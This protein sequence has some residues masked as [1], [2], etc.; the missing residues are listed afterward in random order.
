MRSPRAVW[1]E[2]Q[3]R[4]LPSGSR[5]LDVGFVGAHG[6]P[7]LHLGLRSIRPDLRWLGLDVNVD[8]L[9]EHA[10]ASV[11]AA[12]GARLPF[13]DDSIDVLLFLEVLEHVMDEGRFFAEFA[14]VL[15]PGGVLLITT[16]NAWDLQRAMRWWLPGR[17]GSRL[18]PAVARGYLGARDHVRFFDPLSLVSLLGEH[19]FRVEELATRNH[20]IPLLGRVWRR[21]AAADLRFWPFDR[22]GGYLCLR[23]LS[24][25][26]GAG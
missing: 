15:A 9:A 2:E 26:R 25:Q 16:P 20:R 12:D 21:A 7:A 17:L 5:A 22:L 23:A 10:V 11:V 19:G 24:V 4:L 6:E 13:A 1:V 18:D 8:A 3:V 14:R